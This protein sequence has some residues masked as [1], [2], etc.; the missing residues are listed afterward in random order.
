MWQFLLKLFAL[1]F[2]L[3]FIGYI[4]PGIKI[5]NFS[6]A[7]VASLVIVCIN[8]FVKPIIMFFALPVNILTLGISIL[9]INAF[10]FMLTAKL[11][12]GIEINNFWSAFLGAVILSILS[13]GI[14]NL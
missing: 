8:A 5:E 2:S 1:S 7:I 13:I 9:F 11:V 3:M 12:N 4:V 6:N 10:L 14:N